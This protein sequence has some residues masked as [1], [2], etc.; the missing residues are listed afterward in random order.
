MLLRKAECLPRWPLRDRRYRLFQLHIENG[1]AVG[2]IHLYFPIDSVLRGDRA[3]TQ[4][5]QRAP[6]VSAIDFF[7]LLANP[8]VEMEDRVKRQTIDQNP[9]IADSHSALFSQVASGM[10]SGCRC[11]GSQFI[12]EHRDFR[13][14]RRH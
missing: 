14:G 5:A 1:D 4:Q 7:L 11:L 8:G 9:A 13:G 12:H 10:P 3:L 2:I 6:V